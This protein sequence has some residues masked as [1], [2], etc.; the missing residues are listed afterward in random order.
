M[1]EVLSVDGRV[2]SEALDQLRSRIGALL[3]GP[4]RV[5]LG[6]VG[7]P[8]SGKST[9]AEW[10]LKQVAPKSDVGWVPMDGFHLADRELRRLGRLSAKG[11]IDTFDAHG[12]LATLRRMKAERDHVVYAPEFDRSIEQP[13]AGGMAVLPGARLIV[14]EGNYLLD[15]DAPWD[16]IRGELAAVWYCEVPNEIRRERLVARHVRFGKSIAEA[17]AWV[18]AVDEPNARRI[19]GTRDTANLI[20]PTNRLDLLS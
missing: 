3:S 14:T 7:C 9:L 13:I 4:E 12:Y 2:A 5:I 8:G 10:I 19:A 1:V 18:D 11:A 15:A 16:R 20:I 6:I 17:R